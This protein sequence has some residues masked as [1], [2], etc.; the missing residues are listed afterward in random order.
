[1][2]S[3]LDSHVQ[4][5]LIQKVVSGEFS[6]FVA[7]WDKGNHGILHMAVQIEST[8][9]TEFYLE[10]LASVKQSLR[11]QLNAQEADVVSFRTDRIMLERFCG[12]QEK[13]MILNSSLDLAI[14]NASTNPVFYRHL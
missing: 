12:G 2:P 10:R 6:D 14:W 5:G 11:K 9:K 13:P 8:A 7:Y 4:N 1:M 3:L